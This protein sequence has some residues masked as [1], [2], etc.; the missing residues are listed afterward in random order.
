MT[1][2]PPCGPRSRSRRRRSTGAES[3]AAS[4]PRQRGAGTRAR[5]HR[6]PGRSAACAA[7]DPATALLLRATGSTSSRA[8]CQAG[9]RP[10]DAGQDRQHEREQEH[11]AIEADILH[12]NER[13][14]RGNQA[15]HQ[16]DPPDRREQS[17]GSAPPVRATRFRSTP[18]RRAVLAR[19]RVRRAPPSA[20]AR[21]RPREQEVRRTLTQAMS[22]TNATAP[23]SVRRPERT[24]RV[25]SSA[26][27]RT[28]T[29]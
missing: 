14:P 7:D 17:G 13:Q 24:G 25:R 5:F 20:P 12:A 4:I 23:S 21:C 22:S 19:P 27:G 26:S 3:F 8:M 11:A 15:T 1:R 29:P 9:R 10:N 2:A 16:P 28:Y 6:P 18:V